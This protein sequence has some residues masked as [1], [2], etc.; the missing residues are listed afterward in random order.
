MLEGLV[1]PPRRELL[2]ELA[3][4]LGLLWL[5]EAGG[6]AF[7]SL[8][9]APFFYV[10]L[11]LILNKR[12]AEGAILTLAGLSTRLYCFFLRLRVFGSPSTVVRFGSW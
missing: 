6:R 4:L 12:D 8:A 10:F 7:A 9:S 3:R 5:G 11:F 1:R 2:K